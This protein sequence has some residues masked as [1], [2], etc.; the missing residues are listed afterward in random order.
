MS[1]LATRRPNGRGLALL[2][3]SLP[4]RARALA[5]CESYLD[6]A[7]FFFR[8]V[9]REQLL[10]QLL[11]HTYDTAHAK[12]QARVNGDGIGGALDLVD[13]SCY[14]H[15]LASLFFIFSL[16]ALFD[17]GLPP[18]NAQAEHFYHM[19][20]AAL[21][22]RKSCPPTLETVQA[23]GLMATYHSLAGKKYSR[24]SAVSVSWY[25]AVLGCL[26]C[27]VVVDYEFGS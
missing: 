10:E 3:T 12:A 19:G 21:S 11:P 15:T 9:K 22:L 24:D 2:E 20:R 8:P 7:T 6:H 25:P 5:L 14:P 4:D 16:G 17:V 1:L 27:G 18:Y 13:E 26:F 23:V